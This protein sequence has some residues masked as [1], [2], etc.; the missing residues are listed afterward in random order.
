MWW[1]S[2]HTHTHTHTLWW[3]CQTSKYEV[4]LLLSISNNSM[5]SYCTFEIEMQF[6]LKFSK[7]L[8]LEINHLTHRNQLSRRYSWMPKMLCIWFL[9]KKS[10]FENMRKFLRIFSFVFESQFW[11]IKCFK[12]NLFWKEN[13]D[14]FGGLFFDDGKGGENKRIFDFIR[15]LNYNQTLKN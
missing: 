10:S 11:H 14:L 3:Q 5:R 12:Y 9:K 4:V 1:N 15:F 13:L 6:R 8:N 2:T 7:H